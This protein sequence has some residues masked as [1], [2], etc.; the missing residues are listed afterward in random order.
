MRY[1]TPHFGLKITGV[2]F[3]KNEEVNFRLWPMDVFDPR[4]DDLLRGLEG[5]LEFGIALHVG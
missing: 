1:P 3:R 5:P 4:D 2:Q